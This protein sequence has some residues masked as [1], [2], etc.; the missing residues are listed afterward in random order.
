MV[1]VLSILLVL[2]PLLIH[3]MGHWAVLRR[4]NVPIRQVWF[5]LGPPLLKWGP[6]RVGML[7]I[8]GAVV[9]DAEGYVGLSPDQRLGVALAGPFASVTY[10]VFLLLASQYLG[11]DNGQLAL[12]SLAGLNFWLAVLNLVPVP[13]L[14]GFQ[15]FCAWRESNGKPLPERVMRMAHKAGSG[16]VYGVGFLV[17]GMAFFG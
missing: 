17:L 2:T 10:G 16:F 4:F 6:V 7:P 11:R 13:P 5:G 1:L 12:A 14:D 3:E 15:A 9:P 8:G